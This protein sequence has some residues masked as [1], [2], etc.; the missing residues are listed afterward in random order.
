MS[1]PGTNNSGAGAGASST[2]A[3]PDMA[4]LLQQM[5]QM[6]ATMQTMQSQ[7]AST[8]VASA[9]PAAAPAEQPAATAQQPGGVPPYVQPLTANPAAGASSPSSSLL[10]R[11][12]KVEAATLA[13]II[14]HDFRS[15]DLYKLDSKYRDKSERQVLAF[16]GTS[17]EVASRDSVAKEYKSLNSVSIPLSVYF[18]ILCQAAPASALAD[19]SV[20]FLWYQAHLLKLSTDYEWPA[21]LAYHTDFFNTRRRE[22]SDGRYDGWGRVDTD[23]HAEH[24]MDRRKH[25]PTATKAGTPFAKKPVTPRPTGSDPCRNFNIGR[26]LTSPCPWGRRMS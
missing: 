11:F 17:I 7:I 24:L 12:P 26:C 16:N 13:S 3:Q 21:V 9:T 4:A 19:I 20:D 23:L 8:A 18:S 14:Q 15:A 5:Q 6:Q 1:E 22:M 2:A 25:T 10:S